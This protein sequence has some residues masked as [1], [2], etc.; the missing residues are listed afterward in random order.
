MARQ[1]IALP[2]GAVTGIGSLPF[3]EPATAVDFVAQTCPHIPF[4]PELPQ[5]APTERS[6]EQVCAPLCDL[7]E[8]RTGGLGYAILPGQMPALLD[9]LTHAAVYLDP[10]CSAGFFAFTEALAAGQFPHAVAFKGQMIGPLTLGW[11]LWYADAPLLAHPVGL[12]ALQQYIFRLARWQIA[13]LAS[14]GKPVLLFLD[15]PC[16]ALVPSDTLS[17]TALV[18]ALRAVIK[19]IRTLGALVGVHTC[20]TAPH[21]TPSSV[22]C[23]VEPDILSFDAH[24][25]LEAFTA[26]PAASA[27]LRAGGRVAFGLIPTWSNLDQVDV[28]ALLLRWLVAAPDTLPVADLARQTLITATCGLGLLPEPAAIA[29]F[30]LAHEFETHIANIAE[31]TM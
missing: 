15:E 25:G 22:L 16:L 2:A 20:A 7:L 1:H 4:W 26:D 19:N 5:R 27:F 17:R 21:G 9:R 11:H 12:A 14:A 23:Q 29:S 10:D 24:H 13:P 18:D 31:Q 6:V 30:R 8:P 3:R 28:N